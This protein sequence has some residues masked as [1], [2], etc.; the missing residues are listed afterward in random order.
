[1]IYSALQ[2]YPMGEL[3]FSLKVNTLPNLKWQELYE[4]E[5]IYILKKD[6]S[7][8]SPGMSILLS[9]YLCFKHLALDH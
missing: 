2:A 9:Y 7:L 4:K 8:F 1:M 6:I 5:K 3:I